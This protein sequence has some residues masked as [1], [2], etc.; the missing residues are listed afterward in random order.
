M[1]F[2]LTTGNTFSDKTQRVPRTV[3]IDTHTYTYIGAIE[4][5]LQYL[6]CR[7]VVGETPKIIAAGTM[8]RIH[9][10]VTGKPTVGERGMA[11]V[12]WDNGGIRIRP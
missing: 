9:G 12:I 2:V 6:R 8:M 3:L 11:R 4:P 1:Y 7:R 10:T 5:I